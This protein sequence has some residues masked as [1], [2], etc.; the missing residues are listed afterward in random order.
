MADGQ[1]AAAHPVKSLFPLTPEGSDTEDL[2]PVRV[3]TRCQHCRN[4]RR[5]G[6]E[7]KE[8]EN[9]IEYGSYA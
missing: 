6:S 2:S 7:D 3:N 1:V 5:Q 4:T 8:H 9:A